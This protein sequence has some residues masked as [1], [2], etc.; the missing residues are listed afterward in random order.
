M[1]T[2]HSPQYLERANYCTIL[3]YFIADSADSLLHDLKKLKLL[4]IPM[5]LLFQTGQAQQ[6]LAMGGKI[7]SKKNINIST[8]NLI[9]EETNSEINAIISNRADSAYTN[10]T[11]LKESPRFIPNNENK[12]QAIVDS[13][14]KGIDDADSNYKAK[15]SGKNAILLSTLIGGPLVGIIPTVAVSAVAPN[16]TNLNIPGSG[17]VT[18]DSYMRGYKKEAH[19]IKKHNTWPYFILASV[20]WV[21]AVN[22]VMH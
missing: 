21:A 6:L 17:L 13:Y 9:K 2:K 15:K 7:S 12:A 4:I 18:N 16:N 20:V 19:Y 11:I 5:L 3:L 22:L 14:F 1:K 8:D 10:Q